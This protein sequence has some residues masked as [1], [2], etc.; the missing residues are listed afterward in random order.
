MKWERLLKGAA[1]AESTA[2]SS[3]LF[4]EPGP[5]LWKLLEGI[6]G[7]NT[8]S[9][10]IFRDGCLILL[11][12]SPKQRGKHLCFLTSEG[13]LI[14]RSPEE[15]LCSTPGAVDEAAVEDGRLTL[16]EGTFYLWYC[17]Y[18][19]VEG[20]ACMAFSSDL[21]H[22]EKEIPLLGNINC[23]QNKDHVVF[24]ERIGGYWY[25]LHRPWGE[26]LFPTSYNMPICLARSASLQ[27]G[28]WDDLGILM[29][30]CETADH[31][32]D[33]LGAGAA[34]IP[35]GGGR[36]LTLYH[37]A[38]FEKDGYRQYH[39]SAAIL[40]FSQGNPEVPE[41]LVT[42]RAESLL[43][44]SREFPNEINPQLRISIVFPM[45]C[46]RRGEWLYV[47]YGA[48]DKVTCAARVRMNEL[49]AELEKNP[50]REQRKEERIYEVS[51]G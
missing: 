13:K 48:G 33:W 24:P 10:Q 37:S 9:R 30:P 36:Y 47:V 28:R 39:L 11:T 32:H 5:R 14:Y 18:N 21:L 17:G 3:A 15:V 35:L 41:S 31:A 38:W 29:R 46:W 49:L 34:P 22:W 43:I 27:R 1:L 19:G 2:N 26:K 16:I 44:P 25:L 42:H 7:E 8:S 12:N 50:V 23:G 45:S 4:L 40:D 51:Q 20:R 6:F